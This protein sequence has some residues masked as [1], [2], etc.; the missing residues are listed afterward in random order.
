MFGSEQFE[1]LR[2]TYYFLKD[3]LWVLNFSMLTQKLTPYVDHVTSGICDKRVEFSGLLLGLSYVAFF[4][5]RNL[6]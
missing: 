5:C 2:P 3:S 1:D 6:H 4:S